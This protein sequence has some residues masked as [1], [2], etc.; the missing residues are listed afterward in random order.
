[1]FQMNHSIL[2]IKTG[3]NRETGFLS[4]RLL[5]WIKPRQKP[6]LVK[7]KLCVRIVERNPHSFARALGTLDTYSV[8]MNYRTKRID[9]ESSPRE[10][11]IQGDFQDFRQKI[12]EHWEW[13][14]TNLAQL[15]ES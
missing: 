6:F 15:A 1:M 11:I 14:Y 7:W 9:G 13:R 12:V 8:V 3:T 10:M 4:D 5:G 2:T